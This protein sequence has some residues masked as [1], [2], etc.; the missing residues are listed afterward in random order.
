M[1]IKAPSQI[2]IHDLPSKVKITLPEE[3][4]SGGASFLMF[5]GLGIAIVGVLFAIFGP[6]KI[7][8]NAYEGMTFIQTLQAYPGPI[9]SVGFLIC[10]IANYV[11]NSALQEYQQAVAESLENAIQIT[12]EDIP[13]GFKLSIDHHEGDEKD[14]YYISLVEAPDDQVSEETSESEPLT[15]ADKK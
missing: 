7:Y 13:E 4:N 5:I 10:G 11:T 1:S 15:A 9:A 2:T 6:S 14:V 12:D 8:Y 3:P